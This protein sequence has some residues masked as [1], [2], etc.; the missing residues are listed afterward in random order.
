MPGGWGW[1]DAPARRVAKAQFA[2]DILTLLDEAGLDRVSVM[3]HDWGGCVGIL[4]ALEHPERVERLFALDIAPPW[5]QSQRPH[6]RQ[7]ALPMLAS[8]RV[9]VRTRDGSASA[10]WVPDRSA[11]PDGSPAAPSGSMQR[12]TLAKNFS[13]IAATLVILALGGCGGPIKGTELRRGVQTLGSAAEEGALL[14]DGVW[15]DRTKTTFV[16]VRAREIG[17]DADHEAEKLNDAQSTS[18]GRRDKLQAITLATAVSDAVGD[19][20]VS[21]SN[22]TVARSTARNLRQLADRAQTL[23]ERL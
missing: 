13:A 11:W 9:T 1:T 15:H 14:A 10:S 8:Y 17:E 22:R 23:E 7:L 4:L 18:Q 12:F 3:G 20:Q 6:P 16:R 21:P 19:L 2:A 5:P